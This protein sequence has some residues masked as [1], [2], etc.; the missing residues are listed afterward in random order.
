MK[1]Y[2][3][4]VLMTVLGGRLW[5]QAPPPPAIY[6]D[7]NARY[8]LLYPPTWQ[9]RER[10]G[11]AEAT[12]TAGD[13]GGPAATVR[14]T[15][16]PLPDAQKERKL[17]ANGRS[18]SLLRQLQRLPKGQVLGLSPRDY[19]SYDELRYDYRYTAAAPGAGSNAAGLTHVVGRRIWR[20]GYEFQ[21]E[22]R[23]LPLADGRYLAEG[24]ALVASF[25][26]AENDLPS[27][28]YADQTCDNKLYGI[29]A[30]RFA[31]GQWED[32]CRTIHEFATA[33]PT[34]APVVH[35]RALPFQSYALAKGF[36]N[37]LYA[38]T[39]AP[40][41]APERVYRYDPATRQGRYTAWQLPAQG[42]DNVWISAATDEHGDLY[43]LTS[44]ASLLVK[45]S[46]YD[47]SVT[48]VWA[49]D[50]VRAAPYYPVIGFPGAGTHG[51]F[52]LDDA[53]TMY[54]VY[55]T[56][57]SLLKVNL[58][59]RQ[60]A[61]ERMPL[62]GLPAR[63]GYSDLLLQNDAAGRRR[64]YLAGP[65]A[66]YQVD[67]ARRR[68]TRV[69]GG[70]YTDLA[71]CNLFRVPPRMEPAPPPAATATWQGRVLD[72]VTS[73]PLSAAQLRIVP[74]GAAGTTTALLLSTQATFAYTTTPGRGYQYH[75]ELPGY[76][77]TDSTWAAAPGPLTQDILLR[78]LAVGTTLQ[79]ANVQFE[80]GK[81]ALLPSSYAALTKLINLL[82][83]NPGL[84]IEL[85]GHTDNVGPPEPN[86]VLS[87]QRV[88][89]VKAYLTDHGVPA[90]RVTGRGFGGT[91]PLASNE[92][93][94]TRRLNRRVE[95]RITSLKQ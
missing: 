35:R 91:Q 18:D 23:S 94:A 27:R 75:A 62:S 1:V 40:T 90:A 30:L 36:D 80:Q 83:D 46:P 17:T 87:Q 28:R 73:R 7:A 9:L 37:C 88:A 26:F 12:F 85:R 59:S 22:Y 49:D 52:C 5:A 56:D 41:D 3:T 2:L 32:D 47:G 74:T 66:L 25:A 86:V 60:P 21:V 55:S 24:R 45:A 50:P 6:T 57:G 82:I 69:R 4:L 19:G 16:R 20:G 65:H 77:P 31:D 48:T 34:A 72:A 95:F 93:E 51:N 13:A 63:G 78:P 33:D 61:P 68:A 10:T 29:A 67:L 89:A 42:P 79:L 53:N 58:T 70:T 8:Q 14:F 44:D 81:A 71:G 38:V 64:L 84:T 76:F 54:L 92:Q 39:K 15:I 43:F 11:G